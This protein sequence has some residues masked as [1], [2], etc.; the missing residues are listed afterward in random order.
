MEGKSPIKILHL[1]DDPNDAQL[2]KAMLKKANVEFEYFFTDNETDYLKYLDN[3]QVDIILSDYHLPDFSGTE[4]LIL[5]KT[6]YTHIPFVF[7]S[8][9]MGEDV[10]I[11]SLLNG[12]TDYVLKNKL[13]RLGSAVKRA[14]KEAQDHKARHFAEKA[15]LQ[16]EENFHRSISESPLGIRIV[17]VDGETIY[18]NKAFLDIYEFSNLEEFNNTPAKNRYT[19]ESFIQHQERKEKRK[20]GVDCFDYEL[21][22]V[23]KNNEIRY[24]KVSRKEIQWNGVKHYQV[25]NL[26][27]T[28]QK[29]LTLELLAAKERAEASEQNLQLKN[30][31]LIE[32]NV[33]IQTILDN[34]PI[35][36]A[37]NKTDE[38]DAIYMNKKFEEI[39]GWT[40]KSIVS[41]ST[42]F[43]K[44]YPDKEYRKV[45]LDKIMA[46]IQT[47][48]PEKMHWENIEVT[49]QDGT[50]RV[51][52]AVNIPLFEQNIMI[53]TVM[54][55]SEL[56]QIQID[57]VKAKE[58]AEESDRLKTAFLHN[59]S[60]EIRTPMNAIVGFSEFLN[61][62]E[63]PP[64]SRKKF[65]EIIVL[66][67]NHLLSIIT[68]IVN[69]ATIE[70]GQEKLNF[71]ETN[72]NSTL[73]GIH[74][75]FELRAEKENISFN[76]KTPLPENEIKILT[77]ETKLV[78]IFNNLIGNALK[79]T[80]KGYINF[81][82]NIVETLHAETLHATSLLQFFVEDTGIGIP[83]KMHD[84]IFKRFRQVESATTRQFG[85]SG[86]GLAISKAY[87][88]LMGGKIWIE[89]ETGK[90][91][92]FYFSIPFQVK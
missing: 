33:L 85:G 49:R 10:A 31:E 89:S 73:R 37:L 57:L 61:D 18:A 44:V 75:Q 63:L 3:Q 29:I 70:A 60:H 84:E 2:V 91:S 92:T 21:S 79:F 65:T 7:V 15:L 5:A 69:I 86:L 40:Y 1:E 35:G 64:E 71:T 52:N 26:D 58:K 62:S 4:A 51:V 38:G 27:I 28:E 8:G 17:T 9:T 81:G 80:Q 53:S 24:V 41:I 39:Y 13:E 77:D 14:Y 23:R 88:E 56:H 46:D 87:V 83:I 34:L 50:K 67:S 72:L 90:G 42:F 30:N 45:I 20:N 47:G 12:A 43:E 68:D 32:K 48:D 11:E 16:S 74:K 55:I 19:T 6:K 25:I 54:D 78:Q 76:L 36:L 59:I 66:S 22:I 82:Y